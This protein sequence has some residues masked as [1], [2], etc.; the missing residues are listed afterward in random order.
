MTDKLEDH[1]DSVINSLDKAFKAAKNIYDATDA[2]PAE[3]Y[4][5]VWIGDWV[6]DEKHWLN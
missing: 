4:D 1:I 6:E 3:K 5:H 2:R